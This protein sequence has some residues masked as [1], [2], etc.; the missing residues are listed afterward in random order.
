VLITADDDLMTDVVTKAAHL[1]R[2]IQ[3]HDVRHCLPAQHADHL[4]T[5]HTMRRRCVQ[6][7]MGINEMRITLYVLERCD[8]SREELPAAD[9]TSPAH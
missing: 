7:L 1:W 5:L 8:G 9:Q 2:Q 4:L 3:S 6:F